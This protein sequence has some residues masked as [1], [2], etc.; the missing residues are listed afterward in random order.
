MNIRLRK[1]ASWLVEATDELRGMR[2]CFEFVNVDIYIRS[3]I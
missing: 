1:T 2:V 3:S